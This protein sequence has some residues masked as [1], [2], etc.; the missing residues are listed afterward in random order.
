MTRPRRSWRALAVV[1][2]AALLGGCATIPT[3]GPIEQGEQV[4]VDAADQFIRVIARPPRAGMTPVEVVQGFL[5]ASASFDGDHAVARQYLTA[6]ADATWRPSAGVVVYEGAVELTEG[7]GAQVVASAPLA[8]TIT[9]DGRYEVATPGRDVREPFGLTQVEGEWRISSLSAGLL[10]SRSDVD[11]AFRTY[12]VYFFDP[13]FSVLVP[14]PRTVPV[15]GPALPTA[16]VR[17]LLAGPSGWLAPAVRTGFPTGTSL[18]L[19]AVPIDTGVAR[20]DLT[21]VVRA[22][23]DETRKA[24]SAQLV[25]TLRQIPDVTAVEIT[26]GGQPL[27]VPGVG[28]PQ[29][30]DSW[31]AVDP[32]GLDPSASGYVVQAGAVRRLLPEGPREV[33]GQA[34]SGRPP[35]ADIAVSYDGFR[36][37][38][39]DPEGTLWVGQMTTDAQ[40]RQVLTGSDPVAPAFTRDGALWVVEGDGVVS[41]IDEDGAVKRVP[42]EGLPGG[43]TVIAVAPA[44]DGARAALVV[45]SRGRTGLLLTRVV[46]RGDDVRLS[47]PI[48]VESR[49]TEVVDVAWADAGSLALLGSD[50]AGPLQVFTVDTGRGTLRAL[51]APTDP[52]S[53]AAAPDLPVLV[54][55]G[56]GA[57]Y[58]ISAGLWTQRLR[59]NSPTY[60]G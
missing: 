51:G 10:L 45:R 7:D 41:A 9:P 32:D 48:R 49:L 17:A 37:A 33:A 16:L 27:L 39:V 3:S 26:S 11:R 42:V 20:V 46:R 28:S 54:A 25:W 2:A 58:Q 60:P 40:L 55:A 21:S 34:G 30:Q 1:A 29:P 59:G 36:V 43:T 15:I 47:A 13:S 44:R 53:V 12:D 31:P 6:E 8:G 38:G 57:V 50:G 52:R 23:D 35:L 22:A 4:G 24:L 56:D 19:D 18:A 5:E 14:D